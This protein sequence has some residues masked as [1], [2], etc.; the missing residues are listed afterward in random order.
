MAKNKRETAEA[1]KAHPSL[2]L[3][4]LP[5]LIF[6]AA[7]ALLVAVFYDPGY[8]A[9]PGAEKRYE[10][11]KRSAAALRL[12]DSRAIPPERWEKLATEFKDIYEASPDWPNRPA[13]FFR[14]AE[15]LEDLA[16][17]SLALQDA[18]RAADMYED[19]A[20]KH[21][22]SRLADDALFRAARVRAAWL[23][24]EKGALG[25]ISVIKKRHADGDMLPDAIA[26]EKTLAAAVRGRTAPEAR[27]VA[28]AE[29][30]E[31]ADEHAAPAGQQSRPQSILRRND[32]AGEQ[33]A[34]DSARQDIGTARRAPSS[35][36]AP[37][38]APTRLTML[39]WDS[40]GEDSVDITLALDG[41]ASCTSR[42][43]KSRGGG[44]MR[45]IL[46]KVLAA[47]EVEEGVS[48]RGS[49]LR[50]VHASRKNGATVL[51]IDF[52]RDVNIITSQ[53][54]GRVVVRAET[55]KKS[56]PPREERPSAQIRPESAR[57]RRGKP[58]TGT[59][60][61]GGM[62]DQ[63]GL[64]VG[65][66]F[67]DPGHGGRDPG[68][69]SHNVLERRITLDVAQT[70]GRL[71]EASGLEVVYSRTTDKAI[72]LGER[73]RRANEAR[74]DL[75]VSVHVN[76]NED[77]SVNG[78]E[79]YYLDFAANAEAARVAAL[80]NAAGGQ[81]LGDMQRLMAD[82]MLNA[83]V[84]ESRKLAGDIQRLSVFRLKRRD[85]TVKNNGVKAAPFHVLIGA[86]MPAVL[87][88][89]GYCTNSA[90][91]ANLANPGYRHALAEGL[92]AG[93]LAYRDGLG[94]ANA[95]RAGLE[96]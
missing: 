10:Q 63:L 15:C 86:H 21:P 82:V 29:K 95:L 93:I 6:A 77:P 68:A 23:K 31:A 22:Q 56:A 90:E 79:T 74:A 34:P 53:S 2:L 1:T 8:T 76:A 71:L 13:A 73:T 36:N 67:I 37:K 14:A 33:D 48:V 66:V 62:A 80:E 35:D 25:N 88:E 38:G 59:R 19:L 39:S 58:D 5:S 89:L 41:P 3:R 81:R 28:A 52:R 40:K 12:D 17:H 9:L 26:L 70:L 83:R 11:A 96:E 94:K 78:F 64:T 72:S 85:F 24:D 7:L 42:M 75:F 4:V 32:S 69:C 60:R 91:A 50:G 47:R 30:R 43:L 46:D 54:P 61:L 51:D 20:A 18:R 45:L 44:R 16:R 92:A 57:P 49:L 27:K 65:T 55:V 87:V 84:E